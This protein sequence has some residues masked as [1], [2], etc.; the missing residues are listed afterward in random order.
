MQGIIKSGFKFFIGAGFFG[1]CIN[2]MYLAVPVYMMITYDRVLF[3]SSQATLYTLGAGVL[4]SLLMMGVIDYFRQRILDQA[5]SSMVQKML[6]FVLKSL[7]GYADGLHD[8]ELLRNAV[9]GGQILHIFDLPWM[10][11]YLIGLYFIHPFIG[12]I[13]IA[14]VFMVG[15]TLILLSVFEKKRYIVADLAFKAN[16]DSLQRS[17]AHSELVSGMGLYNSIMKKYRE[18]DDKVMVLR[19]GADAFQ[20]LTGAALRFF[21]IVASVAVFGT[22]VVVFFSNEITAGAIFASV[23]MMA[24]LFYP[25]EHS[26]LDL[27][28]SIEAMAAYDRLKEFVNMEKPKD[29]LSLPSPEGKFDAEAIGLALNGKM[30]LHN[31][32]F[33][34]NPGESLGI[35]GPSSAGK[36]SLCKVMLG[37]WPPV[38]GKVRLDGAEIAQW[39]RD[40]FGGYVGYLPQETELFPA[41]VAENISRLQAVDS[42][43]VIKAAQKAGVHDMI[44]RLP[45]GYD[46]KIDL[47]GKNL[48]AGQRQLISMARA[49]Y[50]DP[51][52]VVMDEPHT[53]LDDI[54]F[55]MLLH[56]LAHLK[57]EKITTVVITDRPNLLVN[58]D[59]ILVIKDG[60]VAMYGP[61]KDV[62]SQL[63]NRQ[64]PQQ[65]AGA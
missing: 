3:S 50:G 39:P 64:Q 54:G 42:E 9:A 40:E 14:A 47:T 48:S 35:F 1:I 5:G 58:M 12:G 27:K 45:Q 7:P 11:V 22:G 16:T 38:A 20:S 34:L 4:I 13:S 6:P 15:I 63:V 44:L 49:L 25:L 8:L 65:I 28:I 18:T 51:K 57:N 43:K 61:A 29:L 60:Q 17:L 41:N 10:M 46:T 2:L 23:M 37:I 21:Y 53:H 55:K 30:I 26:L 56:A 19:A 36:T 32:S 33:S 62:L 31:I 24:R 52:F 59:K